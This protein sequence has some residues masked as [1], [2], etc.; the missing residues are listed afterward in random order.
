MS[1]I[2][3]EPA[4]YQSTERISNTSIEISDICISMNYETIIIIYR[5]HCVI[6]GT[7]K[8]LFAMQ[9]LI[10]LWFDLFI[11]YDLPQQWLVSF[12]ISGSQKILVNILF[13]FPSIITLTDFG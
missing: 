5:H 12:E 13:Y 9:L 2:N 10:F 4:C 11:A 7:P 1:N 8:K 3:K 6:M